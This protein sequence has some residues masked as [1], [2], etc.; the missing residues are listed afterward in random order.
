MT[1]FLQV[2]LESLAFF[3]QL[4]KDADWDEE[5][6]MSDVTKAKEVIGNICPDPTLAG[7]G[8]FRCNAGLAGQVGQLGGIHEMQVDI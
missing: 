1:A 8:V 5:G 7:V 3:E 2:R 4:S 6:D